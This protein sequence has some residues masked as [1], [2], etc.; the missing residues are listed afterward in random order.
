MLSFFGLGG[1]LFLIALV[2]FIRRRPDT[3]WLFIIL[4]MPTIGPIL[5]I[6][7][8]MVPS[9]NANRGEIAWVER[10]RRT[11]RLRAEVQENPSVGNYEELGMLYLDAGNFAAAKDAYDRAL[12]QRTDSIDTFYRRAIC[13]NELGQF[14]E[15]AQDLERVIQKDVNYDFGRA[16]G[17]YGNALAHTGQT[18][19]ATR[20]FEEAAKINTS[21]E[22]MVLYAEFLAAQG[23][24]DQA[25]EWAKRVLDKR[26]LMP[27]YQRRRERKWL[28]RAGQLA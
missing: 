24:R 9:I 14:S 7:I 23:R 22:F 17:L 6:V 20:V 19:H 21:S 8:E 1:I 2:D 5:Y 16:L 15:T 12:A 26:P 4:L 10:Y 11:N 3:Y 27:A 13:E 28:R 18:E 25:R